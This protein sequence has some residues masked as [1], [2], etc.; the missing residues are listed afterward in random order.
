MDDDLIEAFGDT[1]KLMPYLHLP[2]QAGSDAILKA[3][4]RGHTAE[5]Y[6][7][8]IDRLREIRPDMAITSDFIVGFPGERDE[9]FEDTMKLVERIDYAAAY[10]FKYSR[11]PGTPAAD[12]FSQVPEEVK[13]E[14][15]QRLQAL[16]REQQT[17]FN[18]SQI[19]KTLPVLVTGKAR[20]E[21]QMAGRTPYL[22]AT[23]FECSEDLTGQI[24]NVTMDAATLNSVGG[25]LASKVEP[26]A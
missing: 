7:E 2:I 18:Q 20:N 23:H 22:Q 1:E 4:N 11:R 16:L 8:I 17:R 12:M 3:M 5:R 6:I 13:D 10:S 9:D 21:G 19:G 14:R 26:V 24:V 15:L 25:H